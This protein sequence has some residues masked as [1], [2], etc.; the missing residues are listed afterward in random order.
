MIDANI[1]NKAEF[2]AENPAFDLKFRLEIQGLIDGGNNTELADRF[3]KDLD[4]GTG[5]LRGVMGAGSNRMNLYTLKRATQ[6]LSNY[7][8]KQKIDKAS[9]AIAYDSRNNSKL[10]AIESAKVLAANGIKAW[11]FAEL[12][13]TPML[14]YAV[15][16]LGATAGIVITASHNPKEYNGYKV[17]WDDGCQVTPPHDQG[18]IDEVYAITDFGSIPSMDEEDARKEGLIETISPEVEERYYRRVSALS[19]THGDANGDFGIVFTPIHGTGKTPVMEILNRHGFNKVTLVPEQAEPNG[20]FPTVKSPNP[21]E[22]SAMEMAQDLAGDDDYLIL[23]TD[24]DADRVGC[25]VKHKGEWELLNGNQIG[26]ILLFY[27]LNKLKENMRLPQNGVFVTTIVSS[28]LA[29]KIASKFGLRVVECLTGFKWIGAEIKALEQAAKETFVMGMEESH[30]YLVGDFV[31]DKDAVIACLLLAEAAAEFKQFGLTLIDLLAQIHNIYDF[32][33][34]ALVN[35]VIRG[36]TG[37][38]KILNIMEGLRSQPPNFI[39]G[40]DVVSVTD[41]LSQE[42]K[43]LDGNK[44]IGTTTQP[45]SNVIAFDL[46]DGSRITARPSGTEP[47]IKFYFNLCGTDENSLSIQRELYIRDFNNIISQY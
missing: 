24:P 13:P 3:Y 23:A 20:N 34:D 43:D 1:L 16:D 32:H 36:K 35:K 4:F 15:R 30:G 9:V 26:Q 44:V 8:T 5:G 10:F 42:I 37:Q 25:M 12:R 7:I 38:D 21:E 19:Q 31:R 22:A 47:K 41:F 46:S 14:S 2:W 6:G 28:K 18:I 45:K 33:S 27:Y 29:G 40:I 11:I 17:Y 39:G